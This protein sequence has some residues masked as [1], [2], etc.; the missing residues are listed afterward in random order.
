M[1]GH[2]IRSLIVKGRTPFVELSKPDQTVHDL[3]GRTLA[4]G[5]YR[6]AL[7][8]LFE[9]HHK[10]NQLFLMLLSFIPMILGSATPSVAVDLSASPDRTI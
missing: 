1:T 4:K 8:T 2:L 9:I 6:I 5:T 7:W 3:G 10:Q